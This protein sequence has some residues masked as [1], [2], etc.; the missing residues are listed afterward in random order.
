MY[1]ISEGLTC[2]LVKLSKEWT[3]TVK[4][5]SEL[6]FVT[7]LRVHLASTF[8]CSPWDYLIHLN[9]NKLI[10]IT[11]DYMFEIYIKKSRGLYPKTPH[12][13][14]IW[15]IYSYL[16]PIWTHTFWLFVWQPTLLS[17]HILFSFVQYISVTTLIVLQSVMFSLN[18]TKTLF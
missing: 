14:F 4:M 1:L 7:A 9:D 8:L 2:H 10:Y 15:T 12:K 6:E 5:N 16:G 3:A 17:W 18:G 11:I 13:K